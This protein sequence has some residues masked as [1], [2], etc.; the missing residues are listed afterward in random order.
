MFW[1][2]SESKFRFTGMSLKNDYKWLKKITK[3]YKKLQKITKNYKKLQKITQNYTKFHNI[4]NNYKMIIFQ[5]FTITKTARV[6]QQ[7]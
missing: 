7:K 4:Y 3:N 1:E 5:D 6:L 2:K